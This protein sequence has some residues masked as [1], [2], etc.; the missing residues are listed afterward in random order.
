MSSL[1]TICQGHKYFKS[2]STLHLK[3]DTWVKVCVGCCRFDENEEN[4]ENMHV[5][6]AEQVQ[7]LQQVHKV[8]QLQGLQQVQL[9][10]IQQL[11]H[12]QPVV[13]VDQL[14]EENSLQLSSKCSDATIQPHCHITI[15]CTRE[16]AGFNGLSDA[17]KRLD[18]RSV[19]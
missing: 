15:K 16:I 17:F 11:Q 2:D 3:Q 7:K 13:Q 9:Q 4:K 6:Q 1:L 18:F 14:E 10:Q 12:V 19:S 8:Q 5:E